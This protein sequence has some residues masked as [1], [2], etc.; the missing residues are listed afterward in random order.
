MNI[1]QRLGGC[2]GS[3]LTLVRAPVYVRCSNIFQ[4]LI[5]LFIYLF[6]LNTIL[7]KLKKKAGCGFVGEV[8]VL[9]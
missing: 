6:I 3:A 5:F 2:L 8:Y 1:S 7:I 4:D 9:D